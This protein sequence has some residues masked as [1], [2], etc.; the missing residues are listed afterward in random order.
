[1]REEFVPNL[2]LL[3][4]FHLHSLSSSGG[5]SMG[6]DSVAAY[7]SGELHIWGSGACGRGREVQSIGFTLPAV[8]PA[9]YIHA[10]FQRAHERRCSKDDQ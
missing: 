1:M 8:E 9:Y 3:N 6:H 7:F 10:G 2:R 4:A 5:A